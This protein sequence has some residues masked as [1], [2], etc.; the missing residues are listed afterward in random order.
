MRGWCENEIV[1]RRA[2]KIRTFYENHRQG[3]F[4]YALTITGDCARAEDAVH[5]A[6]EKLIARPLLP[7][8]MKLYAFRC[9]R[10]AA[11]SAWRKD[12]SRREN[13][14]EFESL[15]A[16]LPDRGRAERM[17]AALAKLG[18]DERATVTLKIFDELTFREIAAIRGANQNTIASHYR[19][20]I[21]KLRELCAE[22][23]P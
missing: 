11:V 17:E 23:K 16:N 2:E 7:L 15:P 22:D 13:Y 20:G 18:D 10:N 19:R 6:V 8:N 21:E 1:S 9:V 4:S 3:L 14:F 5:S 12:E